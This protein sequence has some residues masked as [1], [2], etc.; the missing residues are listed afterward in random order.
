M[1]IK[2]LNETE[3]MLIKYID[4]NQNELYHQLSELVKIDTVNYNTY[5]NENQGQDYLEKICHDVNLKTDRFTPES[6]SGITQHKDYI[7]G[8]GGDKRENLVAILEG[9]D[10]SKNVILAAHMDTEVV[11]DLS[12]WTDDPFSGVIRDGKIYG[13]GVVDDKHGV[14]AAWFVLKAF[15]D[16]GIV[17]KK[18]LL[19]GAYCDEERGG[20]NGALALGLKYPCDCCLNLDARNLQ[21]EACGGGCFKLTLKSIKNDGSVASVLDVF[22]GVNLAVE[23]VAELNNRPKTK[24]RLTNAQ[25]GIGGAKEGVVNLAIYTDMTKEQCQAKF[26]E[27]CVQLK[28][29]FDRLGLVTDGFVLTTRFFIYGET[30]KNSKELQILTDLIREETGKDVS[31]DG[32]GLSDLSLL[33]AYC[34]KN[35]FNY[36][37]PAGSA[38]GG[39]SHQPNEHIHCSEYLKFVKKL[40]LLLLRM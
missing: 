12:Q 4:E 17:P 32:S 28:D 8:R 3:E 29:D 23:K 20:G 9:E 5:G 26:D 6:I 31:T 7:E 36:G 27:I 14:I 40:A 34:S 19:L 11:G 10:T 39:G 25:A 37:S 18:N 24:I 16:L 13:R 21:A 33:L 22:E 1:Q 35:S 2:L 15:K 38:D 30:D